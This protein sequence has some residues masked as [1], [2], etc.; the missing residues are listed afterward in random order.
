MR[1]LE[2]MVIF[3]CC[4]RYIKLEF[5]WHNVSTKG[6]LKITWTNFKVYL[7]KS[8]YVLKLTVDC[9]ENSIV[10]A[11]KI[12]WLKAHNFSL[13]V[14]YRVEK[15]VHIMRFSRLWKISFCFWPRLYHIMKNCEIVNTVPD[16]LKSVVFKIA[17]TFQYG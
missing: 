14:F 11:T 7:K 16:S 4:K 3:Y 12:V 13:N 17:L 6:C 15:M 1:S 2:K 8:K 10:Q 5:Q 9:I